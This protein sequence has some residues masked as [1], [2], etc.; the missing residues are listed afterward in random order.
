MSESPE[1]R[2]WWLKGTAG[3]SQES[4]LQSQQVVTEDNTGS[5]TKKTETIWQHQNFVFIHIFQYSLI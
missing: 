5:L 2:Q 3:D 4:E 1:I